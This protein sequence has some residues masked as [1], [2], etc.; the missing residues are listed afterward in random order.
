[1]N[2]KLTLAIAFT[3]QKFRLA[4]RKDIADVLFGIPISLPPAILAL[5]TQRNFDGHVRHYDQTCA[6]KNRRGF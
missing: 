1:M 2:S 3:Y 4:V 6:A 5:V